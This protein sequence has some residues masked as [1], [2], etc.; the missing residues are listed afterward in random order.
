MERDGSV[1]LAQGPRLGCRP[2]VTE[3]APQRRRLAAK[4]LVVKRDLCPD[5]LVELGEGGLALFFE[6]S[7]SFDR[8]LGGVSGPHRERG[9]DLRDVGALALGG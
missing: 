4:A 8:T 3:L 5:F 7:E 2:L 1:R 6:L 9:W